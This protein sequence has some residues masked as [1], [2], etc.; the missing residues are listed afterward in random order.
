MSQDT[1]SIVRVCFSTTV[2]QTLDAIKQRHIN[3]DKFSSNAIVRNV[4]I[5]TYVLVCL[6]IGFLR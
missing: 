3:F 5:E 6:Y 4:S 1:H 2:R